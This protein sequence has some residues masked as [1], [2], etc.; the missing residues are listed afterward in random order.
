V[1][2]ILPDDGEDALAE[3]VGVN[4]G[5]GQDGEEAVNLSG[6]RRGGHQSGA[7]GV[8]ELP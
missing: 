8:T 4:R 7:K 5:E 2:T 3:F 1:E 6:I